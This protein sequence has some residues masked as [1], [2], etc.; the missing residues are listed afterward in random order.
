[1]RGLNHPHI[2][3]LHEVIVNGKYKKNSS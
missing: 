1:L 2:I 3:K